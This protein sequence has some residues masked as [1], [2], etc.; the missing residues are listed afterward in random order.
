MDAAAEGVHHGVEVGADAQAEQRDVVGRVADHGD[1]AGRT[2]GV[3][4]G[5]VAGGQLGEQAAQEAGTADAACE[6]RD[7][8]L[9]ILAATSREFVRGAATLADVT[10]P[11]AQRWRVALESW[12]IPDEL[13]ASS[14]RSPWGHSTAQFAARADAEIQAP[15][16]VSFERAVAALEEVEAAAGAAGSVLDVGSGAGAAGLPLLPWVSSLIAL[17]VSADM[18]AALEV[19]AAAQLAADDVPA[20]S[21]RTVQGSWPEAADE[22][23][24]HDVVLCHH[25]AYNVPDIG[26]FLARLTDSARHRVIVEMPPLHPLTW[27]NPLWEKF[28]GIRRPDE[29]SADDLVAVLHEQGVRA[30]AVDRWVRVESDAT[31][32]EERVSMVTRQLCL[33][34]EREPEVAVQLADQPPLDLRRM[35]TLCWQGSAR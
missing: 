6:G 17:D 33:P 32:S 29:P 22:A 24:V 14:G 28:H 12:A 8:H 19:R 4:V 7:E 3:G 10:G 9:L 25:V 34:V 2:V 11:A 5:A 30:L 15:S 13:V 1:A 18:L 27:L 21:V 31:T 16:G 35:V 26:P 20:V 23:G